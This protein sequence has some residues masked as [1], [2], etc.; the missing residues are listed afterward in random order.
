MAGSGEVRALGTSALA[1]S[2]APNE[3]RRIRSHPSGR[4]ADG[5]APFPKEGNV[6]SECGRII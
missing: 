2:R 1:L 4:N 5:E 3:M 6:V